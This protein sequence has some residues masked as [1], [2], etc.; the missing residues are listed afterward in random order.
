MWQD[1]VNLRSGHSLIFNHVPQLMEKAELLEKVIAG[2]RKKM[3]EE[4]V[5]SLG[6]F[7]SPSFGTYYPDVKAEDLKPSLEEFINPT[8]RI[9]SEVVVHKSWNPI[10]FSMNSA[11][12]KS[13]PLVVNQ[14]VKTDHEGGVHTTIGAVKSAMWE[15]SYKA[16]GVDI[17][18]GI[19]AVLSIDGKSNPRLARL[20]LSDPPGIHSGSTTVSFL[21]DKS[22]ASMKEDEFWNKLGT[23]DKDGQMIRRVVN[24]V[25]HYRE[26]SLVDHGADPFAQIVNKDGKIINPKYAATN[27]SD[28]RKK[29]TIFYYDMGESF[30]SNSEDRTIP[31]DL[32]DNDE[33]NNSSMKEILMALSAALAVPF[34]ETD[35]VENNQLVAA[36]TKLKQDKEAAEAQVTEL[37]A[38]APDATKLEKLTKLEEAETARL[39]AKRA[40]VTELLN[41]LFDGK[42]D[43]ALLNLVNN[44]N[45]EGLAALHTQ[46]ETQLNQKYPL[47]CT[48][49]KSTK[50]SRATAKME[51][52][53]EGGNG[54]EGQQSLSTA[55]ILAKISKGKSSTIL[56][57]Q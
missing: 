32:N 57:H 7:S 12:K 27:L 3:T 50:V 35:T 47:Q 2:E 10:D 48:S 42:A 46:Y 16:D 39:N 51:G 19:N 26:Y 24:K 25:V 11:L 22:H 33:N 44:T 43:T 40:G 55:E 38:N 8:F 53:D 45:E 15:E 37:K 28:L 30:I 23:Y 34:Q 41:K 14:S 54:N 4:S 49:C 18:A 56:I 5:A 1:T 20:I 36:L 31:D 9:L 29:Q 17:P 52:T 21:W 13:V 6:L